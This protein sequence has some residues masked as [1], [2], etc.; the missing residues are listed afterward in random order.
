MK[1]II[2]LSLTF[3]FSL[4]L[5][6]CGG[7]R[8]LSQEELAN[9]SPQERVAYLENY[10]QK[11]PND[12]QAKED[13]YKE[14][15]RMGTEDRALPLMKSII[16]QDPQQTE[17]QFEYGKLMIQRGE[18]MPAYR[19]FL[20]VL[21][22]P[23]A[24]SYTPEIG[25]YLGGNFAI[26]QVTDNAADEAFPC[27]SPDGKK[28][29]YQ[30]HEKGNWDI[31]ERDLSS[32]EVKYITDSPAD[33]ELPCY[34]PDGTKI[35]Y[36]SNA[37]DRRPIDDKFK[38]REIYQK[39]LQSGFVRNLTE[40]VADDWLPRFSHSGSKIVFVSER[41]DLR[42]VPYTE[43]QS[44]I[45][46]M[47]NDGAFHI[48]LTKDSA[49]DGGPCFGMDDKSIFFHSNRTGSYD[50]Y[51]MKAD[52]SNPVMILGE[53]GV[54]EVGPF[55]S[56]DSQ[57]FAFFSDAGDNYDIY[58]AKLNGG[59]IE[60]LTF[61]PAKDTDPAYSPDGNLIAFNSNR[62]GNYDIFLVNLETVSE[63][64]VQELIAR[65]DNLLGK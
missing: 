40:T 13:L 50:I 12:I 6:Q 41:S 5:I 14:Y 28:I 46:L 11:N 55:V 15:L 17:V 31:A 7:T 53:P 32:G 60:R 21:K 42:S 10:V 63:P 56:P 58:R 9:M 1:R 44:D 20:S 18:N 65:L 25:K 34:S 64:T 19:A 62:G 35:I 3:A 22:S 4:F 33:E 54:N 8:K 30:T 49:N 57:Y 29:A 48:R 43:K 23:D 52:G 2:L 24:N 27:F 38:V 39:D 61:N 45:Y 36:S 47:D 26:Q 51:R 59:E 16:E 37:D